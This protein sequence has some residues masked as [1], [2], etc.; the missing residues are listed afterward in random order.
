MNKGK[1]MQMTGHGYTQEQLKEKN[2]KNV[3]SMT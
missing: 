1:N 3:K 2:E